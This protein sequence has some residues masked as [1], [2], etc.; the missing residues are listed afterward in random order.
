MSGEEITY[1]QE[2]QPGDRETVEQIVHSTGF[3]NPAETEIAL[4]LVD[5]CLAK[6]SA[7][8]GYY[9]LFA[10]K[11]ARSLGY[12]CFGPVY[13]TDSSFDLY[14]I[15]VRNEARRM[16]LGLK[17]VRESERIMVRMGA[18]RIY[19]DTS[20]REQYAPTRAFYEKCGY[21]VEAVLK[22]FYAA[23]DSKVI[24]VKEISL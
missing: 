2:L 7:K 5:E 15:V 11:H 10:E 19:V 8:S 17:L 16:G 14:W 4:E 12:A 20:S 22:D 3:F 23:G 9:F 1:R 18:R 24:F 6:G 21:R 13:G